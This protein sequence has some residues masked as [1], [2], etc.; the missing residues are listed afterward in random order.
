MAS[1]AFGDDKESNDDAQRNAFREV[2]D[3][4]TEANT[5]N[6]GPSDESLL[7]SAEPSNIGDETSERS[8][9]AK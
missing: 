4:D 7:G 9:H 3:H 5:N 8:D 1:H 6:T 2:S